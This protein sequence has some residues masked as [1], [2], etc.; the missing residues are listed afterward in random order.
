MEQIFEFYDDWW[1]F[2]TDMT[3]LCMRRFLPHTTTY[4]TSF[5]IILLLFS[6]AVRRLWEAPTE[7]KKQKF[8]AQLLFLNVAIKFKKEAQ[9]RRVDKIISKNIMKPKLFLLLYTPK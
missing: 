7:I 8:A 5:S 1:E 2:F 3:F 4:K 6:L 9:R